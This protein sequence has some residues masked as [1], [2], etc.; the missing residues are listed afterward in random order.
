MFSRIEFSRISKRHTF[1][2]YGFPHRQCSPVSPLV[3]INVVSRPRKSNKQ[4][5]FGHSRSLKRKLQKERQSWSDSRDQALKAI[6]GDVM[7]SE[8]FIRSNRE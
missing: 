5:A 8:K 3:A 6:K 4:T 2:V 7:C 1:I